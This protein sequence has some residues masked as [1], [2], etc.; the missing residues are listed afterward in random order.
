VA[1]GRDRLASY[2]ARDRAKRWRGRE[3]FARAAG[4]SLRTVAR[5][6]LAEAGDLHE[7]TKARIESAL[8][9]TDGSVDRILAGGR[10]TYVRD[11][12]LEEL[13]RLWRGLSLDARRMLV[14][15]AR[16][17]ADR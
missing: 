13:L 8:D 6:E 5:V 11:E 16:D 3:G 9:W 12:L 10:P 7:R 17:G 14:R 4:I 15:L 2:V 1:T